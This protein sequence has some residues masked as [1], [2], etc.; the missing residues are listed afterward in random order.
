[1]KKKYCMVQ[2]RDTSFWCLHQISCAKVIESTYDASISFN[3]FL[4]HKF[5]KLISCIFY[6]FS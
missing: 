4:S 3:D 6:F 2:R 1:M 5:S